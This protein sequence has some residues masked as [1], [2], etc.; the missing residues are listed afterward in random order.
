MAKFDYS[1]E[2][3]VGHDSFWPIFLR[4]IRGGKLFVKAIRENPV[5]WP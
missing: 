4:E 2:V 5:F 1:G 3:S